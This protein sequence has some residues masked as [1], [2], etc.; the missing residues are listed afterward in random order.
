[1]KHLKATPKLIK[2]KIS[3]APQLVMHLMSNALNE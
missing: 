3:K 1:M 2:Q